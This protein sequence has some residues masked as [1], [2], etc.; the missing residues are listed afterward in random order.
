[1][2]GD[3]RWRRHRRNRANKTVLKRIDRWQ[4]VCVNGH[5]GRE[6]PAIGG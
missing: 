3:N 2:F 1:M 6:N 5:V 4:E